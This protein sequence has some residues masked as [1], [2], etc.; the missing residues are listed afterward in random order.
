MQTKTCKK[1]GLTLPVDEFSKNS[2]TKDGYLSTCKMCR[3]TININTPK[4]IVCPVCELEKP[5]WEFKIASHSPTGRMW[6]CKQCIDNKPT[7]IS[8]ISY[9][10]KYD[11]VFHEKSKQQKRES[12]KRNIVHNMWKRAKT[13]SKKY[14]YEFNI[15]ESDIIIPKYCPLLEIPIELG[16]KDD[17]ENSPSLDRID[18][19]KGYIKGNVW[20]ISKKA[21]SM[22]NSATKDELSTFCKN[23]LR[24]SLINAEKESIEVG[25][26]EFLR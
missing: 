7:D 24:Y 19:N 6:A 9:R 14:N 23:L 12:H 15:E 2:S 17:Y 5:Y 1:C 21:N 18:N 10:R 26:K 4:T 16:S 13:R 25:N 20:I 8:E 11:S 22:K 3:G